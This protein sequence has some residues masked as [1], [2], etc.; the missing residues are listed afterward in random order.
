MLVAALV[1]PVLKLISAIPIIGVLIAMIIVGMAFGA[2]ILTVIPFKQ[3][4]TGQTAQNQP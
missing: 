3:S 1:F 2:L 4:A